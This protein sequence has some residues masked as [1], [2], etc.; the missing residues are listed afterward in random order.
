DGRGFKLARKLDSTG[1]WQTWLGDALYPS[2]VQFLSS[3][4]SWDSFMGTDEL[5]SNA[6]I[7]LQLRTRA[8]LFDK[9]SVS[10][11]LNSTNPPSPSAAVSK[12][13]PNCKS[14]YNFN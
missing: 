11:F 10:V 3:P 2:F 6:Q 7:H 4:S 8:L 9:V 5:K 1:V 13:N 12:L 14:C